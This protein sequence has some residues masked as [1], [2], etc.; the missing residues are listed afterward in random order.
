MDTAAMLLAFCGEASLRAAA[1]ELLRLASEAA[2]CAEGVR[3]DVG[4]PY[5]EVASAAAELSRADDATRLQAVIALGKASTDLELA[6]NAGQR[7]LRRGA[8]NLALVCRR[9]GTR[10]A[11]KALLDL[12]DVVW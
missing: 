3:G 11:T 8:A 12:A 1:A 10:S 2:R 4:I 9:H 7:D 5:Q 6:A